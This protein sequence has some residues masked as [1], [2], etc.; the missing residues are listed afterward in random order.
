M[1]MKCRR[2]RREVERP[3]ALAFS[4]V[5]VRK[6]RTRSMSCRR[7]CSMRERERDIEKK[8]K[9]ER[10]RKRERKRRNFFEAGQAARTRCGRERES[11]MTA[12]RRLLEDT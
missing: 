3:A 2:M 7:G 10:E 12:T 4:R 1:R 8:R 9:K 5:R 11:R 6:Q